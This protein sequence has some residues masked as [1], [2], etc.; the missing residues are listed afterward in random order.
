MPETSQVTPLHRPPP[1]I[2]SFHFLFVDSRCCHLLGRHRH[3]QGQ[4][5]AGPSLDLHLQ[6][7][8]GMMKSILG[9]SL[10]CGDFFS[11]VVW[12]LPLW[13]IFIF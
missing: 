4:L 13:F 9:L 8:I 6:Q 3:E 11:P 12:I 7:N 5:K 2:L 1:R 10:M